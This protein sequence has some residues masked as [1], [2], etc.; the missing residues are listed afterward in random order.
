MLGGFTCVDQNVSFEL[1]Q[2]VP[3][4]SQLQTVHVLVIRHGNHF[5]IS[6]GLGRFGFPIM[7]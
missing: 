1:H 4:E 2:F 6:D 5:N 7:G 3:K